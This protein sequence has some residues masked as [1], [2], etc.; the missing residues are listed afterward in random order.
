[1]VERRV[2]GAGKSTSV[3]DEPLR[4]RVIAKS[5]VPHRPFGYSMAAARG[6]Q[7][8]RRPETNPLSDLNV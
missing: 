4:L 1:M 3:A 7:A 5:G 8:K 6:D 2:L